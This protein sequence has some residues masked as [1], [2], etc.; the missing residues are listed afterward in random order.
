MAYPINLNAPATYTTAVLIADEVQTTGGSP[1]SITGGLSLEGADLLPVAAALEVQSTKGAI[2]A[3]RMTTSQVTN[4]D[5]SSSVTVDG[6]MLFDST[7]GGFKFKQAG[8]F[9]TNSSLPTVTVDDSVVRWYA[10]GS[11][12]SSNTVIDDSKNITGAQ[13]ISLGTSNLSSGQVLLKSSSN[14]FTTT[15]KAGDTVSDVS[16]ILDAAGAV[17][18]VANYPFT[19]NSFNGPGC[20]SPST[21]I[22]LG[23]SSSLGSIVLGNGSNAHTLTIRSGTTT[24]SF[25]V[26]LPTADAVANSDLSASYRVPMQVNTSNELGFSQTLFSSGT[27]GALAALTV[28]QLYTTP[29][30]LVPA[31]GAGFA[32]IV[33]KMCVHFVS[34]TVAYTAG[35]ALYAQYGSTGHSANA[36]TA[37]ISQAFMQANTLSSISVDGIQTTLAKTVI[38]NQPITLTNAGANFGTGNGTIRVSIL[39]SIIPVS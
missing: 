38:E 39:Y 24:S 9:I 1:D 16:F 13:S 8:S 31:P 11:L 25:V 21:T 22:S 33:K 4:L 26:Y 32:I 23:T 30:E 17:D 14:T 5:S 12:N 2:L 20:I 37:S 10:D 34:T 15:L 35:G 28:V 3:P 29:L 19:I 7:I 36:A 27:T 6:M 18:T